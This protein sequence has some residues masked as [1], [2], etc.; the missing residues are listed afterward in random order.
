[1]ESTEIYNVFTK[2]WSFAAP[3]PTKRARFQTSFLDG[4]LYAVGGSSGSADLSEVDRYD[5]ANDTWTSSQP[6]LNRCSESAVCENTVML[7]I[8]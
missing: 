1:M 3:S 8:Y 6:L 2:L 7:L 4:F 5:P